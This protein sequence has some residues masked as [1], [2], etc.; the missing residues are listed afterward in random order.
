MRGSDSH[1]GTHVHFHVQ[2]TTVLAPY[3][4]STA[5]INLVNQPIIMVHC[6]QKQWISSWLSRLCQIH[7]TS[8]PRR[9]RTWCVCS[10]MQRGSSDY[11]VAC[12]ESARKQADQYE[13]VRWSPPNH[14]FT[15]ELHSTPW[16]YTEA[17]TVLT[18]NPD[19]SCSALPPHLRVKTK[20]WFSVYTAYV[21]DGTKVEVSCRNQGGSKSPHV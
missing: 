12:N 6:S 7:R 10:S 1:Q 3:S 18:N 2:I 5:V 8:V 16:V 9:L 15:S 21:P 17:E 11:S 13:L 20:V 19:I 4:T 14:F